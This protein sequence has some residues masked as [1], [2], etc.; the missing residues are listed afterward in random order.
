M[1]YGTYIF[2][3]CYTH[4]VKQNSFETRTKMF[5]VF[6]D[7]SVNLIQKD[8]NNCK[9]LWNLISPSSTNFIYKIEIFLSI[10]TRLEKKIEKHLWTFLQILQNINNNDIWINFPLTD[11]YC[12]MIILAHVYLVTKHLSWFPSLESLL[13][14]FAL[15]AITKR[16][17][18]GNKEGLWLT[19]GRIS[20]PP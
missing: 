12:I 9:K 19:E 2:P 15:T 5:G 3:V 17:R 11:Y 6:N 20:N 16:R 7:I 4:T 14:I 10:P 8:A 18:R 1:K 13:L